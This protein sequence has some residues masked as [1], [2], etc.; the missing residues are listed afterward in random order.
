MQ[1]L[2]ATIYFLNYKNES[3][4]K[5]ASLPRTNECMCVW[6]TRAESPENFPRS[7]MTSSRSEA[8]L[9]YRTTSTP[10]PFFRL[11]LR[12]IPLEFSFLLFVISTPKFSPEKK[13]HLDLSKKSVKARRN[14][15]YLNQFMCYFRLHS[16]YQN[17]K[18]LWVF[19][20]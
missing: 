2:M 10:P 12:Y 16:I 20:K 18:P 8:L 15:L 13:K 14:P 7:N 3:V 1:V 5:V 4:K 19:L 6:K 11:F 17:G 9:H